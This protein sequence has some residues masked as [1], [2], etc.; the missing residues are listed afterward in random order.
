MVDKIDNSGMNQ[1][2]KLDSANNR[3]TAVSGGDQAEQQAIA[4]PVDAGTRNVSTFE[5]L[6]A[7]IGETGDID[8][9]KVDRIKAA[10]ESGDYSVNAQRVARAVIDLEHLL[11]A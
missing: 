9:E 3:S 10:I 5:Q 1:P 8:R 6:Q 7:K 11:Q 4:A 2:R